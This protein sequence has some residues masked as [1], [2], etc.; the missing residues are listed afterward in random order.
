MFAHPS[1]LIVG[2]QIY[3]RREGW[4]KRERERERKRTRVTK[5]HLS[6][7]VMNTFKVGLAKSL[8][9]KKIYQAPNMYP[10]I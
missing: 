8:I 1:S 9:S 6:M 2:E 10:P 3:G 5:T 4:R 7:T